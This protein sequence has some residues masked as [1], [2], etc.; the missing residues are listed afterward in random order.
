MPKITHFYI[1]NLER[2]KKRW[3]DMKTEMKNANIKNYT[4]IEAIDGQKL[5]WKTI[6]KY[7]TPLSRNIYTTKAI[8]G[9]NL[10]HMKTWKQ[11]IS[12]SKPGEWCVILEDDA[13]PINNFLQELESL[14]KE[15]STYNAKHTHNP[16][17]IVNLACQNSCCPDENSFTDLFITAQAKL[18][19]FNTEKVSETLCKPALSLSGAGYLISHE[20]A[21]KLLQGFSNGLTTTVDIQWNIYLQHY[22]VK[23]RLI[24]LNQNNFQSTIWNNS[25]PLFIP[26]LLSLMPFQFTQQLS[27]NCKVSV[28]GFRDNIRISY[29]FI[30]YIII[31][32]ILLNLKYLWGKIFF[33]FALFEMIFTIFINT[34]WK[35]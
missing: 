26:Y 14:Q 28:Y 25:Y 33:Y 9:G 35:F 29:I 23:K 4:R 1:I 19:G 20:G 10:S 15:I 22:A 30:L 16:I 5:D 2:S 6:E 17:E 11:F 13:K 8:I 24:R 18:F 3:L 32:Y 21:F 12:T 27:W 7:T 34:F 31:G